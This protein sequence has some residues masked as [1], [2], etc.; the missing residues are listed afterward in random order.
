MA[1]PKK[2]ETAEAPAPKPKKPNPS[3]DKAKKKAISAEGRVDV[4]YPPTNYRKFPGLNMAGADMR[5]M[6]DEIDNPVR[7]DANAPERVRHLKN[8]DFAGGDFTGANFAGVIL[9]GANFAGANVTGADFTGC[10]LRWS[11]FSSAV[12][13]D[14]DFTDADIRESIGLGV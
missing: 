13:D 14:A 1:T 2:D 12:I 5:T 7:I 3:L 4:E 8:A 6:G 9:Q 11:N 10:D